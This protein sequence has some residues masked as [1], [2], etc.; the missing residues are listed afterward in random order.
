MAYHLWIY[1]SLMPLYQEYRQVGYQASV[2]QV[3]VIP[4]GLEVLILQE[5][6]RPFILRLE[7][8]LFR[9]LRRPLPF[10]QVARVKVKIFRI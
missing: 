3:P 10:L 5:L 8:L 4:S 6:Q 9:N 7:V 2:R 1:I